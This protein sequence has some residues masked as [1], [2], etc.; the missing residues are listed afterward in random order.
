MKLG[1]SKQSIDHNDV[2]FV[3]KILLSKFITQGPK[4]NEFENN[5]KKYVGSKYFF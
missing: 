5:V 1:Y 2:K 4:V 3:S